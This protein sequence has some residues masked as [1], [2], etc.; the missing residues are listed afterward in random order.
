MIALRGS[1]IVTAVS[2]CACSHTFAVT[3]DRDERAVRARVSDLLTSYAANAQDAVVRMLDPQGFSFY[4]SDLAELVRSEPELRQLMK[5]DF[6]LWQRARFG[7]PRDLAVRVG[8]DLAAAFFNVDFFVRGGPAIPVR[9]CTLWR[10][11][12]GA[13][14]LTMSANAVPTLG[15]SAHVLASPP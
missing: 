10:K 13:W 14:R 1:L 4:G 8:D 12:G 5:D 15:S 3:K 7:E 2:L 6:A 9:L 11:V